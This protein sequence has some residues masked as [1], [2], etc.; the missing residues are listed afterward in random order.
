MRDFYSP[1]R[2]PG[3]KTCNSDFITSLLVENSLSNVQYVEPYAGGAGLA[4]KLLCTD[5]V[6]RIFLND[7][8][9]SIYCFWSMIMNHTKKWLIL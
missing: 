1:L 4:F 2:Y 3:G 8:D 9:R 6:D 7:Y 5:I